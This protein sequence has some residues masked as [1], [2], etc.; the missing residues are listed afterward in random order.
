MNIYITGV[1]G[2]VGSNLAKRLLTTTDHSING[3]V[4]LIGGYEDNIPD[5]VQWTRTD[6][7]DTKQ[8]QEELQ[9]VDVLIHTAALP[10]EGLSVFS[11]ALII[12]NI[13]GGT[14]S[15]ASAAIQNKVKRFI[16]CIKFPFITLLQTLNELE[17]PI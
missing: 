10:Y 13:V 12:Q 4:T 11:P 8:M 16:F 1:A 15:L 7:C 14:A 3:C 17:K 6:I 2:L 9:D 5:D